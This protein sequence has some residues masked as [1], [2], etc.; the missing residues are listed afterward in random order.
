VNGGNPFST[1][2]VRMKSRW[3]RGS[4]WLVGCALEAYAGCGGPSPSESYSNTPPGD[5]SASAEGGAPSEGGGGGR[6]GGSGGGSNGDSGTAGSSG[7]AVNP[8]PTIS[9]WLGT[10][11]DGD[12]PRVDVT[13]QLSPFDTPAAQLDANGYP[14]AGASGKSTT[15][16]GF[17]LPSGTYNIQYQGTGTLTVSGIGKLGG[18]WQTVNGE[19][20]NTLQI[21]GTP[22][23]FGNLLTL[24]VSNG[25]GQT[26]QN[27]RIYY[28]GFDFDSKATFLPQFIALLG[29]FRAMR[30]MGWQSINGSTLADWADRPAAAH[31][32]Q[33]SFGE[34]YEHVTEL[35]N[36]TGKDCWISVPEHAT[37]SFIAQFATF[38]AQN[39]DF[40]RIQAARDQ[41]GFTTP[42]QILVENSNETWNN[43]FTAY[44]TFLAAA[45]ADASRYPGTYG[46]SYGPSWMTQSSDLMKVAEFEADRLVS[47]ARAF[48]SAFDAVG[49]AGAV[50]PVLAGWA[51]GA[52]YS[53]AGLEFIQ[54]NYGAPK[55][56]VTYVAQAPYFQTADDTTT[57][58]LATLFPALQA[59]VASM[60]AT[61]QD[62]AKLGAQ[63]G[64][65]IVAYEGG[66]SLTGT[67]NQTIKHLAQ[68]DERMYET[69]KTYFTLWKKDFGQ[70]L[71]MN[72]TLAGDPGM[73]ENIYQ[74]GYWGSIIGVLEDPAMCEPNLPM[75]TGTEMIP[76][77]V[78]HCPKYR[79]LAEE[80]P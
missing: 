26:V 19:Q 57:G 8:N 62:F 35:V 32:G 80:V 55:D 3:P 10:N 39:L 50:A 52:G 18:A 65:G 36:E 49:H 16:I 67:T 58:S 11:V 79:A 73:P 38:M 47:I 46:G 17:V 40:G 4:L 27:I 14:T 30:F 20:R 13:Y 43:G 64:V 15:D 70:S 33:S 75:L 42:F 6:D 45:N 9:S 37:D 28:P 44:A 66:Q 77:V 71:F 63:Y 56:Y 23:S 76:S 51:L 2:E 74:Y 12:L 31:F 61:F 41:A 29:P 25:A 72:F 5:A 48:R 7:G 60:D 68:H 59:N 24:D 54:A 78:H 1:H 69:Y 34:P 53:D 21:T 22:G